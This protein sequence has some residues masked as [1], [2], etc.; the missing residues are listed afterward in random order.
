M[1]YQQFKDEMWTSFMQSTFGAAGI[2]DV[3]AYFAL[4]RL[5]FDGAVHAVRYERDAGPA[6]R[7]ASKYRSWLLSGAVVSILVTPCVPLAFLFAGH[8]LKK[9]D[10]NYDWLIAWSEGRVVWRPGKMLVQQLK[11][12][13]RELNSILKRR[14]R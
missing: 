1:G 11:A 14:I 13:A 3:P 2:H 7:F 10:Q 6:W 4:M 8:A 5:Q 9:F 12:W